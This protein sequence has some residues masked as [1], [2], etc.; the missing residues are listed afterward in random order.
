MS[1]LMCQSMED[2]KFW[3]KILLHE[4][5]MFDEDELWSRVIPF[6]QD[7]D[8]GKGLKE[9]DKADMEVFM[10]RKMEHSRQ[11]KSDLQS[12]KSDEQEQ[13]GT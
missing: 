2:G 1:T 10:A 3:F 8:V 12:L 5:F 4:S 7:V 11:Y 6:L 9:T 13:S